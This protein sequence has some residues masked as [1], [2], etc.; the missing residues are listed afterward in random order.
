MS[1]KAKKEKQVVF[2]GKRDG[3]DYFAEIRRKKELGPVVIKGG[4]PYFDKMVTIAFS[5]MDN[6]TAKYTTETFEAERDG[7]TVTKTGKG[8]YIEIK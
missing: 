2:I 6:F 7:K 1:Q 3:L 8:L 4:F 5:F